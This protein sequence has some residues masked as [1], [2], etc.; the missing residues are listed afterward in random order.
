MTSASV[1]TVAAAPGVAATPLADLA[2]RPLEE[3][4]TIDQFAVRYVHR[5]TRSRTASKVP[6]RIL[7]SRPIDAADAYDAAW[8]RTP[9]SPPFPRCSTSLHIADLFSGCGGLSLGAFEACRALGVKP[10]FVLSSDVD[11]AANQVYRANFK[12]QCTLSEPLDQALDGNLGAKATSQERKLFKEVERVD[13][14]LAGPPCQG[15]SDLNN[16][17]R[18]TDAKN[19][20]VLRIARFAELFEPSYVLIENVQGIRHDKLGALATTR[21]HL[22]KLGYDVREVVLDARSVGVPQNRRRYFMFATIRGSRSFDDIQDRFRYGR[23]S[24][25]WATSDLEARDGPS[26]FDLPSNATTANVRRMDYLF[27]HGLYELPDEK[28]PSCHAG[29]RHTYRS[30]YGRLRWHEPAPTI[31]T[32]FGCMGQGRFVHPSSR[33]TLTPHEAARVQFF[34]DFFRF[35]A[36]KRGAYQ[37]LIGNAVPPKLAYAILLHQLA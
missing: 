29:K 23:R 18:R 14:V 6:L 20:L 30:V 36:L 19:R 37:R 13:L 35:G 21:K 17:T 32:G 16:H 4:C 31:T 26:P 33:R 34:P 24:L 10:R 7:D 25:A 15:H 3:Y 27:E 9:A 8:L 2:T 5:R 22:L 11:Q 12:P 28:R 1:S